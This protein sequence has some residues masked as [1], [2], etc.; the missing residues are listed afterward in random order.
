MSGADTRSL[1]LAVSLR[2]DVL[3]S[4]RYPVLGTMPRLFFPAVRRRFGLGR[5]STFPLFR[6]A[7]Y[8]SSSGKYRYIEGRPQSPVRAPLKSR[9]GPGRSAPKVP[10]MFPI[11]HRSYP[12]PMRSLRTA[13]RRACCVPGRLQHQKLVAVRHHR[14]VCGAVTAAAGLMSVALTGTCCPGRCIPPANATPARWRA[15][16]RADAAAL[17]L[18]SPSDRGP[19]ET[20]DG[21]GRVD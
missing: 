9:S 21:P 19:C 5:I 14:L 1:S 17:V 4:F 8:W 7:Y 3:F 12:Q 11:S 10:W 13:L 16:P 15:Y 6:A 2:T 20:C 18:T